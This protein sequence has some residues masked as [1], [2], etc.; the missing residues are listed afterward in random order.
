MIVGNEVSVA[1][2]IETGS[3]ARD[4]N[5]TVVARLTQRLRDDILSGQLPFGARLK[6]R[7]LS[8]RFGVS[9]MPVRDALVKL[10]AEGLV[11]LQPNRGASVR[12]ID[13]QFIENLFD[14]RM[15]LEELLVRRC[16]ARSSDAELATL[17]PLAAKHAAAVQQG[18]VARV[19][20]ANRLFHQR[21]TALARNAD[22]SQ[23][24]EQG[25][26]LIFALRRQVGY[27]AGRLEETVDEHAAL[28]AAIESRDVQRAAAIAREHVE[29]SRD[30]ALKRF[31]L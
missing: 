23:I 25:M 6:L 4:V 9:N 11:E 20:A 28:V 5:E 29:L 2:D 21:I 19:L 27:A 1:T 3:D 14:I 12:R 24:L 31:K 8:D 22:A 10:S 7:E 15:A 17:A 30:D 26:A 18:D 16:I 13:Q